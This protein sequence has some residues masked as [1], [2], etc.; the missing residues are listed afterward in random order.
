MLSRPSWVGHNE[1]MLDE[2]K[3]NLTD[4]VG[5]LKDRFVYVYDFGD[6]WEYLVELVEI[7]EPQR[8]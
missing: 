1:G 4:L 7:K 6:N 3:V 8:V 2:R 5:R